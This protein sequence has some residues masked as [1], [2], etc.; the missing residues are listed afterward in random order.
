MSA[1]KRI[2]SF[3]TF[4]AVLVYVGWGGQLLLDRKKIENEDERCQDVV[5]P[6]VKML[7][8]TGRQPYMTLSYLISVLKVCKSFGT[9]PLTFWPLYRELNAWVRL[10]ETPEMELGLPW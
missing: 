9:F 3:Y 1:V 8:E 10:G 6:I 2:L 7:L 5:L 4:V